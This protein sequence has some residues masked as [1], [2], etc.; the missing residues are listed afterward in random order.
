MRHITR[1]EYVRFATLHTDVTIDNVKVGIGGPSRRIEILGPPEEY[2]LETNTVWSFPKRGSWA[3]HSGNYRGNW[4]PYIP[5]NLIEKYTK[6]GSLVLDQMCG[7]GTTLIEARLLGR[8][9]I[10]VDLNLDAVMVAHDRLNFKPIASSPGPLANNS[11]KLYL[12]DARNLD[13]M[14]HES[15]DLIATHPPYAGIVTYSAD[16]APGDISAL[17]IEGYINEMR[18]MARECWRVLRPGRHCGIMIGD[19]RRRKHYVPISARVLQGFLEAGFILKED[20]IK[21]QWK[22]K[23]TREKWRG[24]RFD[25]YGFHKIAH[26]HLY[27]FRKP[28]R[29]EKLTP[30]K[31][32][33]N[34]SS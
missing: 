25:Y 11:T 1:Q 10:G 3:T 9:A 12:G 18:S 16:R 8:R 13:R 20:I 28:E 23:A 29:G 17:P 5:R 22:M 33:L 7:S 15:V 31:Y 19:T 2:S 32:S 34:S 4:S 26:E 6:T 30:Y 14:D 24:A 27:V 21:L